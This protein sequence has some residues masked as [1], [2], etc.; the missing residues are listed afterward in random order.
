MQGVKLQCLTFTLCILLLRG[1]CLDLCLQ[2]VRNVRLQSDEGRVEGRPDEGRNFRSR[3]YVLV[4]FIRFTFV[5]L[6]LFRLRR[7]DIRMKRYCASLQEQSPV[8]GRGRVRTE[9]KRRGAGKNGRCLK[10]TYLNV[11]KLSKIY[12]PLIAARP[13]LVRI[14]KHGV[15]R[16]ETARI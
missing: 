10:G 14:V 16:M 15:S 3:C 2:C 7:F 5:H 9:P 12:R 8:N 1:D 11:Q 6:R 4:H 13:A